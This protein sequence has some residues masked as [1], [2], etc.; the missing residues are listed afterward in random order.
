MNSLVAAILFGLSGVSL[1][2][3]P[4]TTPAP[5][6]AAVERKPCPAA[7]QLQAAIRNALD[8]DDGAT[9]LRRGARSLRRN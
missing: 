7:E 9:C 2:G 6:P 3:K 4:L 8:C 1:A 5:T